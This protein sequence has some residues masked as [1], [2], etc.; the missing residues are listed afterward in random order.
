MVEEVSVAALEFR[1][2]V[3]DVELL[4]LLGGGSRGTAIVTVRR[5]SKGVGGPRLS[6]ERHVASGLEGMLAV[7]WVCWVEQG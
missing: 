7:C 5:S 4:L 6:I 1:I 2:P 3:D